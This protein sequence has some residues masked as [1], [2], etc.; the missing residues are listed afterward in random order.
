MLVLTRTAGEKIIMPRHEIAIAVLEISGSRVRLGI[1]APAD[2]VVFREEVWQRSP[3]NS[4]SD[5]GGMMMSI[6]IMIADPDK[7]L[8]NAY[9]EQFRRLGATVTTATTGL[10]CIERLRECVPDVLIL[11]PLLLWGDG[12]GVLAMM[13]NEPELRPARV[14]LLTQSRNRSLHYRLS[15][16]KIDDYQT[17]PLTGNRLADRVSRLLRQRAY[18]PMS[19]TMLSNR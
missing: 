17:K 12:E 18:L 7:Y 8:L 5:V 13:Q 3:R 9:S 15:S 6:Q 1:T 4:D 16:F 10:E 11:E 14:I 2:V 19:E